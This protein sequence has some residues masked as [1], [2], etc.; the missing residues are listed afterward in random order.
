MWR[1]SNAVRQS[2]AKIEAVDR[3]SDGDA[4]LDIAVR[5]I[6]SEHMTG[7]GVIDIFAEAG[8]RSPTSPRSMM[9][10]ARSSKPLTRKPSARG[11]SS[12]HLQRGKGP[13]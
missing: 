12:T 10:S 5:Q 11:R 13:R 6:I 8:L 2:I 4:A 7:S 9:S 1:S 3:D